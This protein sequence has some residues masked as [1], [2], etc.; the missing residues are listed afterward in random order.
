M[1]RW[2]NQSTHPLRHFTHCPKCGSTNILAS[3][4]RA[5]KCA[6]CGFEFFLNA[7]AAVAAVI[8]DNDS[9]LLTTVR[10]YEPAP[11]TLDLPGGF[12]E[13]NET[14]EDALRREL[15]EELCVQPKI[16][17]YLFSQPNVYPYSGIDVHTLD[18]FFLCHID[19]QSLLRPHDDVSEI[20]W[21][22][23]R[24]L[25]ENLF[26]LPSMRAA[27]KQLKNSIFVD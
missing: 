5:I 6:D 22:P 8:I 20:V 12:I 21:I 17:R 19:E 13:F 2:H 14:A 1:T 9:R 4:E 23:T 25:D 11:S 24:N 15:Q 16:E 26:G 18:M 7:A 27:I 10:A 3:C